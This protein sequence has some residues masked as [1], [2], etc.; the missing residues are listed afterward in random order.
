MTDQEIRAKALE[1]T[2]LALAL[3]PQE[4]RVDMVKAHNGVH[5]YVI[6]QSVAFEQNIRSAS[7]DQKA[8]SR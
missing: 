3:L 2:A 1:I 6:D 7:T 8:S 5:G 4:T